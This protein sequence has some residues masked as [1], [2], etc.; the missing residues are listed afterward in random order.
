MYFNILDCTQIY[1]VRQC[2]DDAV[3][4]NEMA[5]HPMKR[6]VFVQRQKIVE[7]FLS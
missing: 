5:C 2:M 6:S 3:D 7:A 4:N 1:D